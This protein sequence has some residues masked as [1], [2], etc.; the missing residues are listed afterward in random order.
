MQ[1]TSTNHIKSF[2]STLLKQREICINA[3][4]GNYSLK[5]IA[6][7]TAIKKEYDV[8]AAGKFKDTVEPYKNIF[9]RNEGNIRVIMFGESAN[10]HKSLREQF[11]NAWLICNTKT[12]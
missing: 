2:L 7:F 9:K 4:V 8:V 12:L 10:Q 3:E 6:A 11:D 5:V 1:Y